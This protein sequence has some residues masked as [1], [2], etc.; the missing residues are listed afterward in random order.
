MIPATGR[1]REPH[2]FSISSFPEPS[3]T[4]DRPNSIGPNSIT[5][6]TQNTS[7]TQAVPQ[8]Q[9]SARPSPSKYEKYP[10]PDPFVDALQH[11]VS[12]QQLCGRCMGN[13]ASCTLYMG[14]LITALAQVLRKARELDALDPEE[15]ESQLK[16]LKT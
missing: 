7:S 5:S 1:S 10:P 12:L 6:T 2:N 14:Q 9:S 4:P 16:E 15:E 3:S 11:A 13:D 8:Q